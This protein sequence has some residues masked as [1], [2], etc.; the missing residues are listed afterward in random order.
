MNPYR[1]RF[2]A[3]L[4]VASTFAFGSCLYG[5]GEKPA[6]G[7]TPAQTFAPTFSSTHWFPSVWEPY[8]SPMVPEPKMTNSERLH[9]LV[10][11][12]KLHLSIQDTIALALE[13]NL[14]IA[15]NRYSL[16]FAQTD[17]LR[18][19]GGGAARGFTGSFQSSALFAGALGG[20]VSA[21]GGGSSGR[22]GGVSG[23]AGA[24]QLGGGT[25]DPAVS[26]SMGWDRNTSPLGTTIVTGVPFVTS[27]GT[28][29]G[30]ALNQAFQTGTGYTVAMGGSRGTTTSLTPV[31]NPEVQS[32]LAVGFTQPL[33]NGFGHRANSI[34]IRIAKNDLKLADSTFRQQVITTIAQVLNYYWDYLSFKENVGV[35]EQALAYSQK[36]LGDNKRQVEIGTL[37]P[38]EVVRAES[39]VAS[40]QQKLIVAQ[41]SLQQQAELIKTALAKKVDGELMSAQIETMDK[42]PEPQPDDIPSLEEALK[43]AIANRPEIEQTE[44]KFRDQDTT[45]AARRNSLLPSLN[46]FATYIAV[47]LAGNQLL[48]PPG[49]NAYGGRC[50]VPGDGF[51]AP[52]GI[53]AGGVSNALGQTWRGQYP[54]YS[55]GVNLSIPIRNRSAQADMARALLERRQLETQLQQYKNNI[56]QQV[57]SAEI[58]VIQARAQ[59]EAARRAVILAQQTLDAEQKK[60]QLGESTVFL[61]IQAQ[62]DLATAEGNQV[63]AHST[64]AKAL[65]GFQQQT[66][67]ILKKYGVE[68]S[69]AVSGRVERAPNIPGSAETPI[70]Q[71]QQ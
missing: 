14:D 21:G 28:N 44:L 2:I 70:P 26:F 66:A 16:S 63:L 19:Q 10:N 29:Y 64:Y 15:V 42:L 30:V 32:Y 45:I 39:E 65:T 4:F 57:R 46:V 53:G 11:D 8:F 17:V 33:L 7:T 1:Q 13:N 34:N 47:G 68:M 61:V 62:R 41:T 43:L 52:L 40:D 59:N 3:L 20:G 35:A 37:A 36:L 24:T 5:Q 67:T 9:S 55:F 60:F 50:A 49:D 51:V 22:A 18:T 23:G 6:A 71:K 54:D 69:D 25:F 27:Q 56:A 48:C 38:I 31:F 58:A 12:G